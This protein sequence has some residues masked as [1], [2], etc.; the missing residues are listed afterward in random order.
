MI[1]KT[2]NVEST[3]TIR[4]P[5]TLRPFIIRMNNYPDIRLY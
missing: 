3:Y 5:P 4:Q 2:K 1:C